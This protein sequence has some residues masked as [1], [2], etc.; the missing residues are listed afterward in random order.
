MILEKWNFPNF[1]KCPEKWK[2][3]HNRR[4]TAATERVIIIATWGP[5]FNLQEMGATNNL[6]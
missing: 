2:Q 1:R 6:Q 5:P 4:N 3:P